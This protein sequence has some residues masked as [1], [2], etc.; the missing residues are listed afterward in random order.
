VAGSSG[1][2]DGGGGRLEGGGDRGPEEGP[3]GRPSRPRDA[4]L[5]DPMGI[6]VASSAINAG[7]ITE[8]N[9]LGP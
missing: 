2:A 9:G 6:S 4:K 1:G 3:R 8:S 7:L 5:R